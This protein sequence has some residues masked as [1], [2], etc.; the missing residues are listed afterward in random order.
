MNVSI[1]DGIE[2]FLGAATFQSGPVRLGPVQTGP[3]QSGP[4][5]RALPDVLL[6]VLLGDQLVGAIGLEVM[7]GDLAQD[8]HVHREVHLQ[9]AVLDVVVPKGDVQKKKTQHEAAGSACEIRP[10]ERR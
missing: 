1:F 2:P 9:A 7:G 3:D 8:L 4:A 5:R 6:L 10:A